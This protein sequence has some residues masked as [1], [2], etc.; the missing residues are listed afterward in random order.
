MTNPKLRV[1][2][3]ER[4]KRREL[5]AAIAAAKRQFPFE[6][7]TRKKAAKVPRLIAYDFE[8]TRI[9]VG[10][11]RPLYLTAYGGD[12]FSIETAVRDMAHL[13]LILTTQFLTPENLGVKFVAWN[14]NRFDAFFVAAALVRDP[15]FRIRPYLTKS[16]TLRG[17]RVQPIDAEDGPGAPSWEFLDGIAML[18]LAGVSLE[19]LLKNFAPE[20]AKLTGAVDFDK[21]EFDPENPHH[22]EYA[23]RDSEGLYHAMNRAQRIMVDTFGEPLR[24]TMGGACIRVFQAHIPQD[25]VIHALTPEIESVVREY[26]MRGGYCYCNRRYTGPVWKYDL[27]QAYA[28]AMREA[29]LPAGY[30]IR[31]QHLPKNAKFPYLVRITAT[32]PRNR[33]AFYYRTVV[34]DRPV[35]QFGMTELHDTWVTS[36]EH[37]QLIAEGWRVEV[38][39]CVLWNAAFNMKEYVDKLERLRTT[40][41]GGPSGPIGT[42]VKATGNHSYGKTVEQVEPVEFVLAPECPPDFQPYFDESHSPVDHVYFRFDPDQRPK[43]YHKPQIGAFITAYVRMVVRRAALLAPD[44]WLYADTDCVM[45]SRDLTARLDIDSKRYGAW[46]IEEQGT[47]YRII[48]K[49]VYAEVGGGKVSAKGLNVRRLTDEDFER[50]ANDQPPEQD[51]IQLRRFVDVMQGADMYRAQHRR[52]S[53]P[54]VVKAGV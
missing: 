46:K 43:A 33:V 21:E 28:A 13:R 38:S 51:Q 16:K 36:I 49:K 1:T 48:A 4:S 50:W 6:R 53:R 24:V 30:A 14:G 12:G 5:V 44:A 40:C 20:Y 27:N 39:E 45:F 23:F 34:R 18:G 31:G 22:R 47:V 54:E 29:E 7:V 8:T 9:E 10:T 25:T 11:P 41:E 26:A 19:K 15:S 3:A 37:R 17:L 42:M 32:N 52:G 35:S 2:N